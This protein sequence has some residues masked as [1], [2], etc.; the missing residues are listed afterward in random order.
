MLFLARF[1]IAFPGF[2]H[3]TCSLGWKVVIC[4]F[5]ILSNSAFF[6]EYA[7]STF[8]VSFDTNNAAYKFPETKLRS[9]FKQNYK[10][11]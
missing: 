8:G 10:S 9:I 4:D 5:L 6:G 3:Y 7:E 1:F 2:Y 11:C